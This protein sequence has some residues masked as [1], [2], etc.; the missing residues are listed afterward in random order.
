MTFRL[1]ALRQFLGVTAVGLLLVMAGCGGGGSSI[2]PPVQA[3]IS[4]T[5]PSSPVVVPQ[6][7]TPVFV[8]ITITSISETAL[9]AVTGLPGGIQVK[10]AATDTNPSG[11]LTFTGSAAAQLGTYTPKVVV[12]SAGQTASATFTLVV[13][14]VAKG[15]IP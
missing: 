10:Y 3:P 11:I 7:G 9:V 13:A 8:Q 15:P 5:L 2:T 1:G 14:E 12:N 4:V 6:D